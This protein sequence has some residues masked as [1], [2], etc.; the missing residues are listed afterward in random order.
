MTASDALE[1]HGFA[2]EPDADTERRRWTGNAAE[3]DRWADALAELA[4]RLNQ[5]LLDA[6][7]LEP[8]M[9]VL[10]LG[11]GTGEP[12]LSAARRVGPTGRVAGIDLVAEMAASARRRTA[13]AGLEGLHF[14]AADMT[15]LP[16][17]A[18]SFDAVICRF[19][20]MF[21]PALEAALAE[22]AR[23]LRPGRRAALMVW[24]PLADNALFDIIDAAVREVLGPPTDPAHGIAPLFRFAAP[25]SLTG[26]LARAGFD[27]LEEQV[28]QPVRKAPLGTGFWQAPLA[29]TFGPRLA[30]GTDAERGAVAAAV[31]AAF[32]RRSEQG[33]VALPMHVR[34]AVG[35]I[36]PC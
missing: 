35:R 12:A 30:Q 20:I 24:G 33:A 15:A 9:S 3:W 16:F 32:G 21:V 19:G 4:D 22:I 29:M 31:E 8:G 18:Q 13:I 25:G 23:V 2:A 6:A 26:P 1:S 11:S 10:D 27:E 7:G 17:A 5:P 36:S 34:V 14:T 28:L